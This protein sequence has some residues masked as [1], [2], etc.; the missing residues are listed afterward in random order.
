[1]SKSPYD[2][3]VP[4]SPAPDPKRQENNMDSKPIVQ[5]KTFWINLI[6]AI[7]GV[8]TSIGGSDIIQQNPEFAGFAATGLGI[9][10]IFLR[11]ITTKKVTV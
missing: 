6:T 4:D 10:N 9:M 11:F 5:S 2:A 3:L 8:A 1:M 7:A